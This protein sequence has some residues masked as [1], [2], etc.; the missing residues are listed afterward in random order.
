MTDVF[1]PGD[2]I[3]LT[4]TFTSIGGAVISA[5]TAT[6]TL[7]DPAGAS[8]AVTPSTVIATPNATATGFHTIPATNASAG[9]W[10]VLWVASGDIVANEPD[11]FY[12]R[13]SQVLA[14]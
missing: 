7:V 3:Q 4:R 13:R 9:W 6:C 14:V 1:D 5:V 12:V 11:D 2:R 10:Y 8:T